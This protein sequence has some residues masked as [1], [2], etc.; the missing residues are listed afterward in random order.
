MNAMS[1]SF[2]F[3]ALLFA[4]IGWTLPARA[5]VDHLCL[6]Q[7]V[8][9]GNTSSACLSQC[10][11]DV[12]VPQVSQQKALSP[13][14]ILESPTPIGNT[15][16]PPRKPAPMASSK[17]YA[18]FSQ[19]LQG[20]QAYDLCEQRCTKPACAAGDVMCSSRPSPAK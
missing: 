18:C 4:L 3:L 11:Y 1:L 19:C 10:S 13:H 6:N 14:R 16:L 17:D 9:K 12:P 20:K 15:V 8:S 2:G 5:D 7:C